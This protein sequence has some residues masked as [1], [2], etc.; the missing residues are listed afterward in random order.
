[1]SFIF[2]YRLDWQ[3][4][5]SSS[6]Q[7]SLKQKTEQGARNRHKR[8]EE[9]KVRWADDMKGRRNKKN[10]SRRVQKSLN[11]MQGGRMEKDEQDDKNKWRL[12]SCGEYCGWSLTQN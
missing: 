7:V 12:D 3:P 10:E 2:L 8:E 11:V 6:L 1:M 4:Q 9:E 5:T